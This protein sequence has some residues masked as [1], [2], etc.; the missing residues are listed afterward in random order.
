MPPLFC[1]RSVF[2]Q[3]FPFQILN[4]NCLLLTLIQS[5]CTAV[6]KINEK[7][8]CIR[9]TKRSECMVACKYCNF[10]SLLFQI[11]Q[12]FWIY[13]TL[14]HTVAAQTTGKVP[15]NY[16]RFLICCNPNLFCNNATYML[17]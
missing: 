12:F 14:I 16:L 9:F 4:K 15:Q 17:R 2:Q 10:S 3:C 1:S 11:T 8:I 6:T 7:Y 13:L 5:N